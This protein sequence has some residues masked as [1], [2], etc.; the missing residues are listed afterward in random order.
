MKP[1]KSLYASQVQIAFL[2][3]FAR[4]VFNGILYMKLEK[5]V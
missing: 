1:K 3:R 2:V 5:K 4:V